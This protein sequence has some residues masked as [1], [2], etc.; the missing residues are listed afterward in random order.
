MAA[1]EGQEHAS[2]FARDFYSA[3]KLPIHLFHVAP[4]LSSAGVCRNVCM[5]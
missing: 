5:L 2:G 4:L 1:L 3:F